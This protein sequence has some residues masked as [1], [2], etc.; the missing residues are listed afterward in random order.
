MVPL[1]ITVVVIIASL[2]ILDASNK[3]QQRRAR[4]SGLYPPTGKGTDADVE[5]LIR[6]RRKMMA[7]KL[8]REIHSVDLKEAKE[9]VDEIARGI[10]PQRSRL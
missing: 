9:A 2:F 4:E 7:I 8:Y 1:V 10:K 5:R 3:W 6:L